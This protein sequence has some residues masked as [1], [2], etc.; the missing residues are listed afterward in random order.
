MASL[1]VI[2]VITGVSVML[3]FSQRQMLLDEMRAN[4]EN[5]VKGFVRMGEESLI[6]RNEIALVNYLKLIGKTEGVMYAMLIDMND[7]ILGHTDLSLLGNIYRDEVGERVKDAEGL[8]VQRHS[9]GKGNDVYEVSMPVFISG[10]KE[11]VVRIGFSCAVLDGKIERN[12]NKTRNRILIIAVISLVIG[13]IG[14]L[15][16]AGMMIRPIN[17]L[18]RAVEHIGKGELDYQIKVKQTDEL[19]MLGREFNRMARRLK[20]L[21]DMKKDFVSSVTHEL[22][23]P[24]TSIRMYI[25]LLFRGAGGKLSE[26]Q[27][28][29]LNVI[30]KSTNRLARFIDDL[31]DISKIESGKM[32]IRKESFNILDSVQEIIKLMQPQADSKEIELSVNAPDNLPKINADPERIGQIITNLLSNAIKFTQKNGKIK[33]DVADSAENLR[34]SVIDNG[35]GIPKE[36]IGKI[37]EKFEQVRSIRDTIPGQKG[38]GLGLPI[39]KSIVEAHRGKVRVESEL[40]KGS[41][42]I[43][44]LPK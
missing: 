29:C 9:D 12:L 7:R 10:K 21:D 28:E 15:I 1:L 40:D 11:A 13:F 38:T 43:V 30:K 18:S 23:S 31:L 8:L 26:K 37:F 4:Q 22:R 5:I 25:G 35:A 24:M 19:G 39:V 2:I 27:A 20:E 17:R 33:V 6:A 36:S 41:T 34:I 14:S 16:M 44:T 32:T 42:F 3:F